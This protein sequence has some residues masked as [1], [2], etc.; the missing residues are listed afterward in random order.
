MFAV[1]S[2]QL[3]KSVQKYFSSN[4]G[5]PALKDQVIGRQKEELEDAEKGIVTFNRDPISTTAQDG[6]EFSNPI[7]VPSFED[8][9]P[10]GISHNDS[11]YL[12][13]FPLKKGKVHYVPQVEKYFK[14]YNPS[15]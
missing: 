1:R 14:L 2:K 8:E 13:W 6:N 9:R 5:I 12:M 7:M 10:V 3:S 4:G 15:E 11:S